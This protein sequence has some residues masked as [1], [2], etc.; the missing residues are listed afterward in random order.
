MRLASVTRDTWLKSDPKEV[1]KC[2]ASA[3]KEEGF[4]FGISNWSNPRK[5]TCSARIVRCARPFRRTSVIALLA[6]LTSRFSSFVAIYPTFPTFG[7]LK[8]LAAMFWLLNAKSAR[9]R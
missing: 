7:R 4:S 9:T 2:N 8:R 1:V 5:A 6:V 3:R